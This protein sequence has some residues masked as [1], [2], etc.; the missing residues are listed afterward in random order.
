MQGN[1]Q[2]SLMQATQEVMR[3]S[4][5]LKKPVAPAKD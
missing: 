3:L 1:P 2:L 4:E 5:A